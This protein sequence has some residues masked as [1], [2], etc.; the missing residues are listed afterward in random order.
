MTTEKTQKTKIL[1][2]ELKKSY[3][4]LMKSVLTNMIYGK[5]ELGATLSSRFLIEKVISKVLSFFHLK[6][7]F[8]KPF[9]KKDR[10]Y[11][12]DW[13]LGAHTMVGTRRLDNV[14]FCVEDILKNNIEGDLIEAGVWRGGA[15]IFMKA[16]L[17]AYGDNERIVWVADSFKGLPPPNTEK[18]PQDKGDIFYKVDF[19][20]VS[21][22]EVKDNFKSYNLLDNRVKFL[23]GWFKDTLPKA[24]MKK[25]SLV[26]CDGD[27]YEST[28]DILTNLYDKLSVGGYI[29]IDD[30]YFINSCKE[31]VDDFRKINNIKD[32]IYDIT[33]IRGGIYWKKLQ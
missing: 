9:N 6:L 24:P 28:V 2:N 25:L 22:E 12:N 27:M 16:I 10:E 1:Y 8:A 14:Q 33:D 30:Y 4:E 18:Y 32:K 3:L 7:V 23:V 15:S 26:R 13:P 17:K 11:G 19:L 20:S 5:Y 29:I 31:A 21:L